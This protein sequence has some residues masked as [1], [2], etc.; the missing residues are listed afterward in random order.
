MVSR[1]EKRIKR[2]EHRLRALEAG[3]NTVSLGSEAGEVI[4]CSADRLPKL[5]S[6]AVGLNDYLLEVKRG[7]RLGVKREIA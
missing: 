6:V 5:A 4:V 1:L 7:G 2:L 3:Q